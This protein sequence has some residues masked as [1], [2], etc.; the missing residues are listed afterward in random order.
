MDLELEAKKL[1]EG[2]T[3]EYNHCNRLSGNGL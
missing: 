3:D 2:E 1:D